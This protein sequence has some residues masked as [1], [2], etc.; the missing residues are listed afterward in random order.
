MIPARSRRVLAALM[1]VGT[2]FAACGGNGAS[3]GA[4]STPG[5]SASAGTSTS[6]GAS[7]TAAA[8][9][10]AFTVPKPENPKLRIGLSVTET[11][12][13]AEKLADQAGIYKKNGFTD[14]EVTVFEGDGKTVQ[15]L[16]AGQLDAAMIGVSSSVT[17]QTTDVPMVVISV[18]ATILTDNLVSVAS[19]KTANDLKGKCVAISTYGGTSHGSALLSL[20][21]LGLKPEDVVITEI[22]GQSNRIAALKGG[23]CQA[24]V[25]DVSLSK[26]MT[27]AGFNLLTDLKKEKLPWGRS[28]LAVTKD[29]LA[30]NPNAALALVASGLEAQNLFWKDPDGTAAKYAEFRQIEVAKA[31]PLITDFQEIGNRSLM[32]TQGAFDAPKKVLEKIN[33]AIKDVDVTKAYDMSLLQKLK[34]GGYYQQLGIPLQ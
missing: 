10:A 33:P 26:D 31:K 34:D 28:G 9:A 29:W 22:G 20:Q 14:V 18:N 25:V 7:T 16:Q 19:V 15:A 6:A 2:V 21:T 11:S 3:T 30:K 1:T 32:W 8:S 13:Y 27:D 23:S 4:S 5:A 24:G 12:Q 17:S